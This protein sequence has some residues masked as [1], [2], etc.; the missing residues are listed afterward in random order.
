MPEMYD[1]VYPEGAALF[2]AH[3]AGTVIR[4]RRQ[5]YRVSVFAELRKNPLDDCS[6]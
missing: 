2:V 3:F 5:E 4:L 6:L 1:V